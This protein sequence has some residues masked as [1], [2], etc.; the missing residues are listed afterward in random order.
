[1]A[2]NPFQNFMVRYG[3]GERIFTEGDLGTTMYIVQ[4]GKVRL[5]RMVDGAK[6]VHGTMEK[7]DFFGEMSILEGLP[8]TISAEAVDDA[9]L[10]E[11]NSITFDKMIKGN[12]EIAIR[13]LR[14]LSI[15]LRDA[16]RKIEQLQSAESRGPAPGR[17]APPQHPKAA[18][19]GA[20]ARLEVEG[21]GIVFPLTG[22][23]T[24]IGRYDPVTELKP[25]ID[26]TQ[27]DLK[28]SVSRRHARVLRAGE[29][30][31]LTEE[32]GALNGTFV[33]GTKLVTGRPH[34][35]REG[36]KLGLGM[37]KVVFRI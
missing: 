17:P 11:I 25:D 19:A 27:V 30:F 32:V 36:D 24:L 5:F 12:I 29:G 4:S 20:G 21:E 18:G 16:E 10:I 8:R 7:G 1:M 34:P 26:L 37:V 35:I 33:N 6:R 9:E 31:V 3:S 28:R 14:K 13:M 15:R 2:I 22:D 23:D